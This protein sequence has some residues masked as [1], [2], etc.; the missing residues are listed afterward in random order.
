[1][2]R[3][4]GYNTSARDVMRRLQQ[5]DH[6]LAGLI[7]AHD[8]EN[9]LGMSSYDI[10]FAFVE[11][12]LVCRLSSLCVDIERRRVGI[13]RQ[14]ITE[15]ERRAGE[16]GCSLIELSSGRRTERSDA[17]AFYPMLGYED[18]SLHHAFYAKVLSAE[19]PE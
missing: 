5:I 4:L 17:H 13:G 2:V 1:L 7:V 19:S 15:V 9:V 18:R 6:S 10:W 11:E 12:I 8:G 3:T 14:L 16:A